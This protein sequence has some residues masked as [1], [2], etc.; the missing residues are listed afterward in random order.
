MQVCVRKKN[1]VT[2]S[3]K[4]FFKLDFQ[5]AKLWS[6][7][8]KLLKSVNDLVC[9]VLCN[10]I[11]IECQG[12]F[13]VKLLSCFLKPFSLSISEYSGPSSDH[14]ACGFSKTLIDTCRPRWIVRHFRTVGHC[15][16]FVGFSWVLRRPPSDVCAAR[17]H[18]V[19][20]CFFL[21]NK[22]H[23][24]RSGKCLEWR[25]EYFGRRR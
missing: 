1:R 22:T 4:R 2:I 10:S 19:R 7:K 15:P 6:P 23:K 8:W 25:E 3:T 18:Y 13:V 24:G 14:I 17:S 12:Y 21:R 16:F 5:N 9:V 20:R 11:L